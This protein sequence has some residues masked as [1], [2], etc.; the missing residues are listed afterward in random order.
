MT[1]RMRRLI[2]AV[3]VFALLLTGLCGLFCGK[4]NAA[5]IEYPD[6]TYTGTMRTELINMGEKQYLV[7]ILETSGTLTVNEIN[8]TCDVWLCGGGAGGNEYL[9]GGGGYTKNIPNVPFENATIVIG[10]G[11]IAKANGGTTTYTPDGKE[12]QQALGGQG[13][14]GG[15]GGGGYTS[16]NSWSTSFN[17]SSSSGTTPRTQTSGGVGQGTTTK[18]FEA[19]DMPSYGAGGAGGSGDWH[20]NYSQGGDSS[21]RNTSYYRNHYI[22]QAG[23]GGENGGAGG[24]YP[25]DGA[26]TIINNDGG[27]VGGGATAGNA[28]SYGGGG[29]GKRV[30]GASYVTPITVVEGNGYAGCVMIRIPT[31]HI[32]KN[33]ANYANVD[34]AIANAQSLTAERYDNY[35]DVQDAIDS[36]VRGKPE[37]DQA[38]VDGYAG[39]IN[40]AVDALTCQFTHQLRLN[41]SAPALVA[42]KLADGTIAANTTTD[43]DGNYTVTLKNKEYQVYASEGGVTSKIGVVIVTDGIGKYY[44]TTPSVGVIPSRNNVISGYITDEN[45]DPVVGA[46]IT[47]QNLAGETVAETTTDAT[48]FY[49]VILPDGE[50][51]VV[52]GADRIPITASGGNPVTVTMQQLFGGTVRLS[53]ISDIG[54]PAVDLPSSY[55]VIGAVLTP[56][57]L[58]Q[59]QSVIDITLETRL[60]TQEEAAQNKAM[61][62]AALLAHPFFKEGMTLNMSMTTEKEGTVT[63][64]TDTLQPVTTVLNI[65]EILQGQ[66]EYALIHINE[67]TGVSE[68][69]GD[70][71]DNPDTITAPVTGYSPYVLAYKP[72]VM[73]Q[74]VTQTSIE[75]VP[76]PVEVPVQ[77]EVPKFTFDVPD[78]IRNNVLKGSGVV[79]DGGVWV[80]QAAGIGIAIWPNET[81]NYMFY[82]ATDTGIIISI[83]P[84]SVERIRNQDI[85]VDPA[86]AGVVKVDAPNTGAPNSPIGFV[87]MAAAIIMAL[88]IVR[89]RITEGCS[90]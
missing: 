86:S 90:R 27:A 35:D 29:G 55:Q 87:M 59:A 23:K 54:A 82:K 84:D 14:N 1:L 41:G 79:G 28:T 56:E 49:S 72:L 30:T 12:T 63:P 15:S 80:Y 11:G 47:V 67:K 62:D 40:L 53:S 51:V 65:P 76:T 16:W 88:L 64:V 70:T 17:T 73:T 21:G 77:V 74:T 18:P 50:Y 75:K 66:P 71:D 32:I 31:T 68:W 25:I 48:G 9:G 85:R 46:S 2:S 13:K 3:M 39:A 8:A 33:D 37:K 38:I 60:S 22:Y 57:E 61:I 5:T 69:I 10:A 43:A 44:G 42:Y 26:G 83:D 81:A 19:S 45:S 7:Y 6:V 36:V 24:V 52:C 89:K 20:H 4:A 34:M 58:A 78:E